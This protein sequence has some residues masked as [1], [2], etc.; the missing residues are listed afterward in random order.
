MALVVIPLRGRA[1]SVTC[2]GVHPLSYT[3]LL[4]GTVT[5]HDFTERVRSP[6]K[7]CVPLELL[8]QLHKPQVVYP[9]PG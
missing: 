3:G 5:L 9:F 2:R 7:V 4:C 6:L 8:R 1:V